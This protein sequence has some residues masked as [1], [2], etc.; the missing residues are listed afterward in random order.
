MLPQKAMPTVP[1]PHTLITVNKT[2][3]QSSLNLYYAFKIESLYDKRQ[4]MLSG[5]TAHKWAW[6]RA[7]IKTKGKHPVTP[8]PTP[9]TPTSE[10]DRWQH[11]TAVWQVQANEKYKCINL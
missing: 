7:F 8:H 9:V 5:T 2:N 6:S 4:K 1:V 11:N 10:R 3:K